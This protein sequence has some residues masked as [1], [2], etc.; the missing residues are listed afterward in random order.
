MEIKNKK[1]KNY[2]T[3]LYMRLDKDDKEKC[4]EI[5]KYYGMPNVSTYFRE[6]IKRAIENYENNEV[7]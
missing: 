4:V 3:V 1:K 7:K 2:D 6:L 5:A